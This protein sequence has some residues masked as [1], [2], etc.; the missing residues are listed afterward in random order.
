M[1]NRKT[2]EQELKI[3]F[4]VKEVRLSTG[5]IVAVAEWNITTGARGMGLVGSL[6]KKLQAEGVSGEIEVQRLLDLAMPE[7]RAIVELTLGWTPEELDSRAT[8]DDFIT[9]CEAVIE[10]SLVKPDRGGAIPK[11][12]EL[13]QGMRLIAR[14]PLQSNR[15][16]RRS[17]SSS[18][19]DTDSP[20]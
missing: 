6:L 2:A 4:P 13:V 10:T 8:W 9:L 20:S 1:A 3:L 12:V 18:A 19:A 17:T 7:M 16:Q 11:V 15:S 5:R 14:A